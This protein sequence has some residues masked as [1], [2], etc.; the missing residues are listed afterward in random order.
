MHLKGLWSQKRRNLLSSNQLREPSLHLCS[1]GGLGKMGIPPGECWTQWYCNY[2]SLSHL[3]SPPSHNQNPDQINFLPKEEEL[4]ELVRKELISLKNLK[5]GKHF[6]IF[7]QKQL[8]FLIIIFP[9]TK[10]SVLRIFRV[11]FILQQN[12]FLFENSSVQSL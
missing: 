11:I 6:A 4:E 10:K 2:A 7:S 9:K 8:R 3:K 1:S 12:L 5:K